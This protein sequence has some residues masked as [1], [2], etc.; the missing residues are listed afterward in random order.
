M[1]ASCAVCSEHIG[2]FHDRDRIKVFHVRPADPTRFG[3]TVGHG[4]IRP[5][6][7][8]I[9]PIGAVLSQHLATFRRPDMPP[10]TKLLSNPPLTHMEMDVLA[11]GKTIF[12]YKQVVFHF[13]VS[14]SEGK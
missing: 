2:V 4:S 11:P 8:R 1:W 10:S 9:D 6:R 13:H 7:A 12:H 14:E 5:R 3:H